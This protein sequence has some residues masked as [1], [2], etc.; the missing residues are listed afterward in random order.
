MIRLLFRI[1]GL[2]ALAGGFAQFV[3]DGARSIAAG[4][5]VWTSLGGLIEAA[6]PGRLEAIGP[7]IASQLHPL[8]WDP[9]ATTLLAA[10]ACLVLAL[11]G[12]ALLLLGA[13]RADDSPGFDRR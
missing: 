3:V 1:L 4:A 7:R 2:V 5:P 11:L 9:L 13:R 6:A 8:L 10:P 12:G